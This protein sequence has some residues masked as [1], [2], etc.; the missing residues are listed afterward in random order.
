MVFDCRRALYSNH[1]QTAEDMLRYVKVKGSVLLNQATVWAR[2]PT[3]SEQ[4]TQ[5]PVL[6]SPSIS[7]I[8]YILVSS[9]GPQCQTQR[10][11]PP[12]TSGDVDVALGGTF[13]IPAYLSEA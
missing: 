3:Q 8:R 12:S 4:E 7:S 13:K 11:H 1:S 2:D 5:H 6:S 9:T 10:I